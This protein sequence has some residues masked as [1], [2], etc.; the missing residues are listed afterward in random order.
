MQERAIAG[1]STVLITSIFFPVLA[2]GQSSPQESVKAIIAAAR[3]NR[4]QMSPVSMDVEITMFRRGDDGGWNKTPIQ[5]YIKQYRQKGDMLDLVSRRYAP[6]ET[7]KLVDDNFTS[8]SA[9]NGQRSLHRQGSERH[10]Y[11]WVSKKDELAKRILFSDDGGNILDGFFPHNVFDGHWTDLLEREMQ[12][13]SVR[14]EKEAVGEAMCRVLD[15]DTSYGK[16]TLWVDEDKGCCIRQAHILVG[17]EKLAWGKPLR[18]SSERKGHEGRRY[19]RSLEVT[20]RDVVLER[21]GELYVPIEGSYISRIRYDDGAERHLKRA[22]RRR[23]I[24]FNPDFAA[25]RAFEMDMPEGTIVFDEDF[26]EVRYQWFSGKLVPYVEK[27]FIDMIDKAAGADEPNADE[28]NGVS[29]A[30]K[31]TL[32]AQERQSPGQGERQK[33]GRGRDLWLLLVLVIGIVAIGI[34]INRIGKF[35][36]PH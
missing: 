23:N 6:D 36:S 10:I 4:L 5:R 21:K 31:T 22:I 33:G 14:P 16:Y 20:L 32:Q 11:G 7:G 35:R 15:A 19:Y 2:A 3:K 34:G 1:A 26:P 8:R 27:E 30:A 9:W 24:T 12:K 17:R 18:E 13:V 29:D 25:I 28:V